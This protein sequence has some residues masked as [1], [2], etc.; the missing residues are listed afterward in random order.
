M[1]KAVSVAFMAMHKQPEIP[2]FAIWGSRM[3]VPVKGSDSRTSYISF[4]DVL[5]SVFLASPSRTADTGPVVE[6]YMDTFK[7]N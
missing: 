6:C 4:C 5:S 3:L 7:I 1:I 2:L